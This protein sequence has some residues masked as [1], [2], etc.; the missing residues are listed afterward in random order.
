MVIGC[1][2][3]EHVLSGSANEINDEAMQSDV[4]AI[5][6]VF[7]VEPGSYLSRE[8]AEERLG[9]AIPWSANLSQVGT[10]STSA[11]AVRT[12][13]TSKGEVE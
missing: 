1:F 11:V 4:Y 12:T 10:I 8:K 9:V 7:E 2:V 13:P 3:F 6:I 5:T